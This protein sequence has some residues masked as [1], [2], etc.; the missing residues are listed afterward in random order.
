[1]IL[2]LSRHVL[3]PFSLHSVVIDSGDWKRSQ[4]A[5]HISSSHAGILADTTVLQKYDSNAS[6]NQLAI[7]CICQN[8]NCSWNY[9]F[10]LF[11]ASSFGGKM[12]HLQ[13]ACEDIWTS[14]S[15]ITSNSSLKQCITNITEGYYFTWQTAAQVTQS[16]GRVGR[17]QSDCQFLKFAV[18]SV[19]HAS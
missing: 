6:V 11:L 17:Q 10:I 19:V 9:F 13:I 14:K 4:I 8:I 18:K 2:S 15:R 12:L 16:V 5:A 1:M 3:Y 7:L